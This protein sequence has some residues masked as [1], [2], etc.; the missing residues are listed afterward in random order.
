MS[1]E[2]N[3]KDK[4]PANALVELMNEDA[5]LKKRVLVLERRLNL[6]VDVIFGVVG[7]GP[8]MKEFRRLWKEMEK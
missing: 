8:A 2:P 4:E 6:C 1:A 7:P 5:I 3:G